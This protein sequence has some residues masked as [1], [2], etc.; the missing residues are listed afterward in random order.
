MSQ[1]TL[2]GS[3]ALTK[4]K[5]A[6][7][8]SKKG[9]DC[10]MIPIEENL[11]EDVDGALYLPVRI[12][13]KETQDERG[14]NGFIAKNIGTKHYKEASQEQRDAWKNEREFYTPI[15]GNIKNFNQQSQDDASGVV[16]DEP[17]TDNTNDLPF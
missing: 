16:K 15:L 7:V 11:I 2:N 10:I 13:Y 3:I 14:S 4:L 5:S 1:I 6:R 17:A 9:N 8:K 12:V